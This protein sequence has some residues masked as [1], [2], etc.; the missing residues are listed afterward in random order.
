MCTV[1]RGFLE[2]WSREWVSAHDPER[3]LPLDDEV[4]AGWLGFEPASE[5]ELEAAEQRLGRALPPSLR[6]FLRLTNGWKD[7]GTSVYRLAGT[8]ELAWLRDTTD[9]HWAE[10]YGG[11]ERIARSLRLSL[12]GDACVLFLDPMDVGPGGEWAAYEL[13]SWSGMGPVRHDSFDKL[14][15]RLYASFHAVR[16]PRGSTA[17]GW[18][19]E[20]ERGRLAAMRGDV[21]TAEQV[22]AEAKTFGRD[23][24]YL[25]DFQL[26]IMQRNRANTSL[27]SPILPFRR[28]FDDPVFDAVALPL[29]FVE[30]ELNG[31]PYNNALDLIRRGVWPAA[32]V[33]RVDAYESAR[34]QPGF[35]LTFGNPEFDAAVRAIAD[36]LSAAL[37]QSGRRVE[38]GPHGP[39]SIITVSA[40]GRS[41]RVPAEAL[42]RAWPRLLAAMTLWRPVSDN[43]LAPAV[44]RADPLL[45]QVITNDRGR[46]LLEV[47]RG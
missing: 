24:A 17:D 2:R 27:S 33:A 26:G 3:D 11:D 18:D 28:G 41:P 23:R 21:D 7:A 16:Q 15:R 13:A 47:P 6:A 29:L 34:S 19:A 20:V 37:P 31:V 38:N 10:A 42:D 44:L 35:R 30:G 40:P 45:Q 46:E 36:D 4:R 32:L 43:H 12:A 8:A 22:F 25:L 39:R 9:A 1:D 5:A 14:M